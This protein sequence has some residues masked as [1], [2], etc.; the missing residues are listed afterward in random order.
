MFAHAH[1]RLAALQTALMKHRRYTCFGITFTFVFLLLT[2]R[3]VAESRRAYELEDVNHG[4][5]YDS[6]RAIKERSN[7]WRELKRVAE[8]MAANN[9]SLFLRAGTWLAAYRQAGYTPFDRDN[10]FAVLDSDVPRLKAL[11]LP[12][13]Y[14]IVWKSSDTLFHLEPFVEGWPLVDGVVYKTNSTYATVKDVS[15]SMK[16]LNIEFDFL[17]FQRFEELPFYDGFLRAPANSELYLK[18]LYGDDCLRVQVNKCARDV[19]SLFKTDPKKCSWPVY[20]GALDH[21]HMIHYKFVRGK[22][23]RNATECTDC[24]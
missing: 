1:R 22:V 12:S 10:D 3:L 19:G 4:S 8:S 2:V 14:R 6:I 5:E 24:G 13:P 23:F 21:P 16:Y 20:R 7:V 15:S 17:D 11:T 18:R 9:V